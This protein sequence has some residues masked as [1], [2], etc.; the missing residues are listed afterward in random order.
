MGFKGVFGHYVMLTVALPDRI[1]RLSPAVI[2]FDVT[3]HD[4]MTL[5]AVDAV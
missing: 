5:P 4:A 2:A 1:L 3:A